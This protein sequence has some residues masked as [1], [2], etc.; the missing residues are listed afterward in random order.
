MIVLPL[1]LSVNMALA[2]VTRVPPSTTTARDEL[3]LHF[4]GTGVKA[5]DAMHGDFLDH[6]ASLGF[7]VIALDYTNL[8]SVELVPWT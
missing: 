2:H 6:A 8:P 5:D 7:H 3:L 4:P 1:I